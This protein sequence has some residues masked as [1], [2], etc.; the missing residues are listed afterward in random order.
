MDYQSP[1][2]Y[3]ALDQNGS[4]ITP[5]TK[6]AFSIQMDYWTITPHMKVAPLIQM[7]YETITPHTIVALL[8]QMD[9]HSSHK[10]SAFNLNG[11]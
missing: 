8:I 11:L 1:H 5:P 9:Y 6:V 7:D 10:S 3:G 2:K 4:T